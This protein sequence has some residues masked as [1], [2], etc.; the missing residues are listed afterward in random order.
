MAEKLGRK[1]KTSCFGMGDCEYE[2][3]QSALEAMRW[4]DEQYLENATD[5][6]INRDFLADV[7]QYI[8]EKYL[9]YKIGEKVKLI[10]IKEN[11]L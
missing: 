7:K 4:K 1:Y 6:T 3:Y 9:D 8:H 10:I 11:E 2:T 5:I